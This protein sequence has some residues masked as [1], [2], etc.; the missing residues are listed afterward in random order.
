VLALGVLC[1]SPA[2]AEDAADPAKPPADPIDGLRAELDRY[3]RRDEGA[4]IDTIPIERAVLRAAR[5]SDPAAV[6]EFAAH[7][8]FGGLVVATLSERRPSGTGAERLVKAFLALEGE[9]RADSALSIAALASDAARAALRA[10]ATLE[11]FQADGPRKDV[12]RAAL[13]R[14]GDAASVA[15]VRSGLAS[16]E[17]DEVVKALLLVGDARAVDFLVDVARLTDDPRKPA[18]PPESRWPDTKA[19]KS[20]DGNTETSESV[21]V[22]LATVGDAAVEAASRMFRS[23]LPEMTAWWYELEK[24]PR[25]PRGPDARRRIRQFVAEDAKAAKAK[26]P[27]ASAAVA[28]VW[29]ALRPK[30][31]EGAEARLVS[32]AFDKQWSVAYTLDGKP[33]SATVDA[34]GR[35]TIR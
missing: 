20:A 13:V 21:A 1:A 33:G 22:P 31:E 30:S 23:T 24:G 35:A 14:A 2:R 3:D 7:P 26:A 19:T 5:E 25:F 34:S 28:A 10:T 18:S 6:V 9:A 32:V 8:R 15:E 29:A 16:K 17:P 27:R 12:V 4:G 11:D